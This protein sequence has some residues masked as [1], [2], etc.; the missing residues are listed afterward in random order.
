MLD[1]NN[2]KSH[3]TKRIIRYNKGWSCWSAFVIWSY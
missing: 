2:K 1:D 3:I